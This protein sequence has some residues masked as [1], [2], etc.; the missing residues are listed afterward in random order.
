MEI[1]D[2]SGLSQGVEVPSGGTPIYGLR[3]GRGMVFK[4][5]LKTDGAAATA[6]SVGR[7]FDCFVVLNK[8]KNCSQTDNNK[9]VAT[10]V[11]VAR[12]SLT[13]FGFFLA[14]NS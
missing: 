6:A 5:E 7:E 1:P 4:S 8:G 3:R 11:D 12:C 2:K 14:C 10:N 9:R 13:G